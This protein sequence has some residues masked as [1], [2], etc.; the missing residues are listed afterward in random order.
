VVASEAKPQAIGGPFSTPQPWLLAGMTALFVARP[1]FPSESAAT[2][3]DG[4]VMVMLWIALAIF[5]LLTSL[6]RPRFV[7][8][9][10]WTDAAVLVL[11]GWIGVAA[12]SAIG[13]GSPRPALNMLWE[14][15]G[16][17]LCFLLARQFITSEREARAVVAVMIA[18]AVGLAGYGLYQR[19]VE[20]P[21]TRAEYAA[22][23]DRA[24]RN[25][26]LWFP[27][28][29]RERELFESRLGN[30]EPLATFALTNSLAAF[31]SPWMVILVGMTTGAAQNRKRM[32]G[33]GLCLLLI[34]ACF[35]LTKSRSG[36]IAS[37]IGLLL[38]WLLCREKPLRIGWKL[39]TAVTA[40]ATAILAAALV[41][42]G[43]DVLAKAWTSFAFRVHYWQSSVQMI[44]D[45]PLVGCGPGNFQNVYTQYKLP[46]AYEEVADPHNLLLEIAATA[47]LPAALAFVI[48]LGCFGWSCKKNN[49]RPQWEC[50]GGNNGQ[51]NTEGTQAGGASLCVSPFLLRPFASELPS[52][53][54][55]PDTWKWI[56]AG[57]AAGFLLSVPVGMLSAA[58]SGIA[59]VLLGLPLAATA[60]AL[61]SGWIRDGRL[62]GLLPV[63]GVTVLLVDLLTTGGIGFPS[64]A[65]TLWLLLALGLA[66]ERPRTAHN[67]V[68]WAA[69]FVLIGLAV[70]C[71]RT[72]YQP[73]M[74]CQA[75]LR[76]AERRAD[77]AVECLEA[78]AAADP[79]AAEP[80]RQLA[81]VEFE[82]WW[83]HPDEATFDRFRHA[84]NKVI[85]LAPNSAPNW[86]CIG[87]WYSRAF[88]R[89]DRRGKEIGN[90]TLRNALSAYD[91]ALRL[92]P[93][94]TTYRTKRDEAYRAVENQP[95]FRRAPR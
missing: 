45:H 20:F 31:L 64:V 28:G 39:P 1:L 34:T 9:F 78:A 38:L 90:D 50:G 42:D 43:P 18:L 60:A 62:P 4:L 93:N 75:Q 37:C 67:G 14:W 72:A 19:V 13:H 95:E 70:T 30:R 15:L 76:L 53:A 36:Y 11:I 74:E 25:A 32:L 84:A 46:Q 55:S 27:P 83:Q 26:G 12:I 47:G 48:V 89:T 92:Y 10:G 2:H 17:G 7:V 65:N 3:G 16:M 49:G 8:R 71:Y 82:R 52:P 40:I 68:A 5:W 22:D 69:F 81:A 63:L 85:E 6:A 88:S 41:I 51:R 56:L 54:V 77:R 33:M 24:I 21:Q 79:W 87:D 59:A 57:G 61:L 73:V 86:E 80:W 91:D 23:P 29:S 94:N 58:P 35:L 44:A 66:G